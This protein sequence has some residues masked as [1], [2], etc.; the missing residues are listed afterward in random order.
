M[1]RCDYV[2]ASIGS[3]RPNKQ[4]QRYFQCFENGRIL[5][6]SATDDT[7]N[8]LECNGCGL[9]QQFATPQEYP[10]HL[11]PDEKAKQRYALRIL[12]SVDSCSECERDGEQRCYRY[13]IEYIASVGKDKISVCSW[14]VSSCV[15]G[16]LLTSG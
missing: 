7:T 4:R 6:N 5:S 3:N 2:G 8:S 16:R 9:A 12:I 14:S 1:N 15:H 13:N 10:Y 11:D